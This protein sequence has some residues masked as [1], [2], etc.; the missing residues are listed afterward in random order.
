MRTLPP[1]VSVEAA[2]ALDLVARFY[3]SNALPL[4][5]SR[6]LVALCTCSPW[7]SSTLV[8]STSLISFVSV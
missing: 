7:I 3:T 2:S 4:G 6:S 1:T 5:F 8:A